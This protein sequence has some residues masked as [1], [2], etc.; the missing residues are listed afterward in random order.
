M[1]RVISIEQSVCVIFAWTDIRVLG[2]GGSKG[3][4]APAWGPK[5]FQFHA[6]FGKIWQ[7]HMLAPPPRSWCPLLGEILDPPL[8]GVY[9]CA[10]R[11][12]VILSWCEPPSRAI[13]LRLLKMPIDTQTTG[14]FRILREWPTFEPF[15]ERECVTYWHFYRPQRKLGQGNIFRSVSRILFTGGVCPS[16]CYDTPL[17][18]KTL[19]WADTPPWAETPVTDTPLG[20]HLPWA[21]TPTP[22][23]RTDGYCMDGTHPTGFWKAGVF[24]SLWVERNP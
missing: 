3:G 7:N 22:L 24:V 2:S 23:R 4:R 8:L 10:L 20:R 19:P 16:A 15:T 18:G 21:D 6:V 1:A 14:P 11:L 13:R 12:F 5:F 9:P 17:S